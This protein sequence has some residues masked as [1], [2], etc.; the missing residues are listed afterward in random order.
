MFVLLQV[1][2]EYK[3][4]NLGTH[5]FAPLFFDRCPTLQSIPLPL[6]RLTFKLEYT[7][8]QTRKNHLYVKQIYVPCGN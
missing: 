6:V 1:R 3:I 4:Y 7:N 2:I 5:K 8:S